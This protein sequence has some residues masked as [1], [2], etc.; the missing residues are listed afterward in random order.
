MVCVCVCS[1]CTFNALLFMMISTHTTCCCCCCCCCWWWWWVWCNMH[2]FKLPNTVNP[3]CTLLLLCVHATKSHVACL[4]VI[5]LL[6][7]CV[8]VC[9]FKLFLFILIS[10]YSTC[11]CVWCFVCTFNLPNTVKPLCTLFMFC[12]LM[13][14]VV[15]VVVVCDDVC[16]HSSYLVLCIVLCIIL[17]VGRHYGGFILCI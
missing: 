11:C 2:T 5:V 6:R 16:A 17:C 9:S 3:W 14:V 1:V 12:F 13:I 7:W 8:R 10:T 4:P 15:V